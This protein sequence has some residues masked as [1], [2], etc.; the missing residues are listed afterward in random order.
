[1]ANVCVV[2]A[3]G[4]IGEH[5]VAGLA[6]AGQRVRIVSRRPSSHPG[7]GVSLTDAPAQWTSALRG[8]DTVYYVAGLAHERATGG[9]TAALQQHNCEL[10]LKIY[11]SACD[12]QV[13]SFVCLSSAKVL[14]DTADVALDESAQL[15]PE[16]AYARS[17]AD[18]ERALMAVAA[19]TR[20]AIVRPP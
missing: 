14:G 20:L 8:I 11:R 16:D 4:F 1:M 5:L 7:L 2:G 9:S 12:A 18:G 10:P 3:G 6:T 13:A 19:A 17:K 15:S